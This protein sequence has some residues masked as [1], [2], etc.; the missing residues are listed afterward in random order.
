MFTFDHLQLKSQSRRRPELHTHNN[1][2]KIRIPTELSDAAVHSA[3]AKD[4]I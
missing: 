4:F 1:T 2:V 3:G